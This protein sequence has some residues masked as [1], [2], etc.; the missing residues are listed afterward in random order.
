MIV[1]VGPPDAAVK[2]SRN[3]IST[4][5]TNSGFKVRMGR[6]TVNLAPA[7]V[8]NRLNLTEPAEF[9]NNRFW[10]NGFSQRH[11]GHLISTFCF[12]NF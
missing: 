4:A 1:I 5:P 9:V 6:T 10:H 11:M 3:R 8:K 2:E 12:P 7:D